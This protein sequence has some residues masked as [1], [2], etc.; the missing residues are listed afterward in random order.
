MDLLRTS[1]AAA[2]REAARG[3]ADPDQ[4]RLL[5]ARPL[6]A[7]VDVWHGLTRLQDETEG[8]HLEKRQAVI[9][10]LGLLAGDLVKVS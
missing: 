6:E 1:L 7:W 2:V 9:A 4:A 8:F 10:S 5:D 3:R